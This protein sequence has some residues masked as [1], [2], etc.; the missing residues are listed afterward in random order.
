MAASF[1][2]LA[3]KYCLCFVVTIVARNAA[4][5]KQPGRSRAVFNAYDCLLSLPDATHSCM[6]FLSSSG[7]G[8]EIALFLLLGLA[9]TNKLPSRARF[10]AASSRPCQESST[11]VPYELWESFPAMSLILYM[12]SFSFETLFLLPLSAAVFASMTRRRFLQHNTRSSSFLVSLFFM[13]TPMLHPSSSGM[14]CTCHQAH[15]SSQSPER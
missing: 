2:I 4:L 1:I 9:R 5:Q 14:S 13:V 10:R 15:S 7:A 12:T 3:L 11:L 8:L 6:N